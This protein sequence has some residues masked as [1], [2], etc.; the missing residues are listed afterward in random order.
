M[1]MMGK[2]EAQELQWFAVRVKHKHVGGIRKTMV[3]GEFE[4]FKDRAGNVRKRRI[5]GT[6]KKVFVSEHLMRRAGFE[7]FLPIEKEMRRKNRF[8]NEKH[9]VAKPL[10]VGWVF[11]GWPVGENRWHDLMRLDV[12]SGVMGAGGVP[13]MIPRSR[14]ARLMR[15]W[16]GGMLSPKCHQ[17]MKAGAGYVA[18]DVVKVPDGPFVDFDCTIIDVSEKAATGV[19]E[20]FGRS[21]PL[22]I[23]VEKLPVLDLPGEVAEVVGKEADGDFDP[24]LSACICGHR[25][26]TVT[27]AKDGFCV[28]CGNC[29]RRAAV[30]SDSIEM[31]RHKW[32]SWRS[33]FC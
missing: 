9:L 20:I 7:V 31:A 3:G 27:K 11:V 23:P 29:G 17:I 15:Q 1:S 22:E 6:G 5:K 18:G 28:T 33:G 32:N 30:G 12:V 2:I 4:T 19:I 16:G 21:T 13:V 14:I 25:A 24:K 10:I 26:A 8:S